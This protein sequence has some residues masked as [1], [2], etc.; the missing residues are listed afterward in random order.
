MGTQ[1]KDSVR[2]ILQRFLT[3]GMFPSDPKR[4]PACVGGEL[5]LPLKDELC[6]PVTEKQRRFSP[7]ERSMIRA[8]ISKLLDRGIIR[9]SKSPWAAQC[10]CVKKKDGTLRL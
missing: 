8:E 9:P 3:A 7:E 6:A 4:V 2:E 10:L 5:T 1:R